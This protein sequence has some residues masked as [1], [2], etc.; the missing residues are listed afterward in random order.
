MRI[1]PIAIIVIGAVLVA[2]STVSIDQMNRGLSKSMA[3]HVSGLEG[4]L[5]EPAEIVREGERTRY[6]WF[7]ES[8]IEPCTIDV[9]ADF[10]GLIR[11]TSWTGYAGACAEF[12]ISLERIF[13]E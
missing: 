3:S 8:H 11:K 1:L 6:R 10:D 13:P 7:S 4:A 9:W 2:C 5:G 12:A